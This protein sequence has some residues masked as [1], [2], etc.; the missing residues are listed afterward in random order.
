LRPFVEGILLAAGESRRMGFPKPLLRI[1]DETFLARAATTML[2][3]VERLIV[4]TG[5]HRERVEAAMPQTPRI[6][7]VHNVNWQL[8]Q[9]SSIKTGLVAVSP[10]ADGVVVHLAD[11]PLVRPQTV[12]G[13]VEK[14]RLTRKPIAVARHAGHRGHPVLFDQSVFGELM[15]APEDQGARVVVNA[16]LERVVY[17]DV[18]DAGVILDLDTPAD[19]VKVGLPP[20]PGGG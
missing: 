14:Y 3:A 17:L 5:A 9:L 12:E 7:V 4:V 1:G 2:S 20:P 15:A 19:L 10:E 8:G 6:S 11:H 13:I 16:D 18:D